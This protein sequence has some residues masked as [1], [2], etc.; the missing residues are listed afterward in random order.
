MTSVAFPHRL[1]M[2]WEI[3]DEYAE[4]ID[5]LALAC[6]FRRAG[7]QD[8]R[9]LE[10]DADELSILHP[11]NN[12]YSVHIRIHSHSSYRRN[13]IRLRLRLRLTHCLYAATHLHGAMQVV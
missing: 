4:A 7:Y 1:S 5:Y 11:S 9:L 8:D 13:S 3:S 2:L 12:P 10:L 6:Q